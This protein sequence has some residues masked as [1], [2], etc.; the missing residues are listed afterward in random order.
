MLNYTRNECI[1]KCFYIQLIHNG[2]SESRR[3]TLSQFNGDYNAALEEAVRL[4]AEL[5]GQ[6]D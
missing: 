6:Y 4:R 3:V 5:E 2:I 1:F